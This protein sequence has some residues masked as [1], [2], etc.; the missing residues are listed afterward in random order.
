LRQG[1][2]RTG[3]FPPGSKHAGVE[4]KLAASRWSVHEHSQIVDRS[5]PKTNRSPDPKILLPII[6][7]RYFENTS[8]ASALKFAGAPVLRSDLF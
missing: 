3:Q 1:S 7:L 6:R 4:Q 5:K 8:E 2:V